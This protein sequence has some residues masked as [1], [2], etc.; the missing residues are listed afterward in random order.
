MFSRRAIVAGA[1]AAPLILHETAALAAAPYP[2]NLDELLKPITLFDAALSPNG[3]FIAVARQEKNGDAR[4]AFIDIHSAAGEIGT[5][6]RVNVG[7]CTVE[8]IEWGNDDR[9]LIWVALDKIGGKPTGMYIYGYFFPVPVRRVLSVNTDGKDVH[10]LF[11]NQAK[12]MKRSFSAGAIIDLMP[13]NPRQVMMQVSEPSTGV[14]NLYLVDIYTGAA[15]LLEKGSTLTTRWVTQNGVPVLRYSINRRGTIYTI[16]GRAPGEKDW[17]LVRRIKR[18]EFNKVAKD[19][20]FAGSTDEPGVLLVTSREEGE[21]T[22]SLRTFDLK[23]LTAGPIMARRPDR[24]ID[25]VFVDE[26]RRYIGAKYVDHRVNY[27][28]ADKT[29]AAHF[30]GLNKF[31]GDECNIHLFD[32]STDRTRFLAL[33][34]GPRQPGA[35]YLYD[36][37]QARVEALGE[38]K[39]R[40]TQDRLAKVEVLNVATRDGSSIDAYLTVPLATGPR[41]LVVMPHGGPEVRDNM[42]FD[43]FAQTFAAQGWLVLQPNFRGSGGLGRSFADAG[44]KHWGDRMQEDVEDAIAHVRALNRVDGDRIA[45]CGSSYGGYAAL[46]GVV[47]N[48]NLYRRAVSIAG[49]SDLPDLVEHERREDGADSPTYAYVLKTIGDPKAD[50]AMLAAASPRRRVSEINTPILLIHGDADGIAP[51][52]QSKRMAAALKKAGKVHALETL[53]NEGHGDWSRD[54]LRLVLSKSVAFIADGFKA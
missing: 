11:E 41:P 34:T 54:N 37:K 20:D 50:A 46:M 23:T 49:L 17:K 9:L 21:E 33:A 3:S 25:S 10:V 4:L 6:R 36:R 32:V 30:K 31:M 27:E 48:K 53:A 1:V 26:N 43:L 13:E 35:Y 45:I 22:S 42:D 44:R 52:D 18:D 28:F 5:A 39:P 40:L 29:F 12:V 24:D 16:E 47:R 7:D 19:F 2:P 38:S 51:Y 14:E 15:T 8:Q